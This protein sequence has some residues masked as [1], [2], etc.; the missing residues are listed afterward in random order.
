MFKTALI[1]TIIVVAAYQANAGQ[2]NGSDLSVLP[3]DVAARVMQLQQYGDR[4]QPVI[5]AIFAEHAKPTYT[6]KTHEYDFSMLP[7]E[8][9]T[10]VRVLL[11]Y[12]DRFDAAIRAIFAD[13]V[14]P[15]W[16]FGDTSHNEDT[17]LVA[18]S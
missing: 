5:D 1:S 15:D 8:T 3:A 2:A 7:E 13:A 9:A 17:E 6:V 10:Q 18:H 12:G 11:K 16:T 14:K 4:Y